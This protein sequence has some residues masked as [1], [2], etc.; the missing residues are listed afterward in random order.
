MASDS[1][2]RLIITEGWL[3]TLPSV[4]QLNEHQNITLLHVDTDWTSICSKC[5]ADPLRVPFHQKMTPSTPEIDGSEKRENEND[6]KEDDV[7]YVLYTSGSTGKPKGVCGTHSAMMNRFQWMWSECELF[8]LSVA[9]LV[10]PSFTSLDLPIS[11]SSST[12][13]SS[14]SSSFRSI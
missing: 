13:S 12:S 8:S 9:H 14:T 6:D 11:S 1:Q 5:S 7:A 10:S 4:V 2:L 3:S